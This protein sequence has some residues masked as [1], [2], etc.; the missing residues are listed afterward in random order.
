MVALFETAFYQFAPEAMM[1]YAVP[2]SWFEA[3]VRRWGFHGA[4]HKY[5]AE[6]SA[7]LLGRPDVAARPRPLYT[8]GGRTTVTPFPLDYQRY[9]DPGRNAFFKVP[10]ELEFRTSQF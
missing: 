8:K 2:Q 10:P 3:G 5:I 7:E 9:N 6:R 1:R 4:S